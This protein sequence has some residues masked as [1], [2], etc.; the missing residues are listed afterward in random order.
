M[1]AVAGEAHG[2]GLVPPSTTRVGLLAMAARVLARV[3]DGRDLAH[4]HFATSAEQLIECEDLD[5]EEPPPDVGDQPEES[6]AAAASERAR[7]EQQPA[8]PEE[9]GGGTEPR[10]LI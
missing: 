1:A 10:A 7:R 8:E 3:P 9:P 6:A 5:A 2:H 4:R